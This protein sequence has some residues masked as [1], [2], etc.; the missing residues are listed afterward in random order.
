MLTE[1]TFLKTFSDETGQMIFAYDPSLKQF[2]YANPAFKNFLRRLGVTDT[3]PG[4]I[5]KMVHDEDKVFMKETFDQVVAGIIKLD[6][7]FRLNLPGQQ[8]IWLCLS[9]YLIQNGGT[10]VI[11]ANASDISEAKRN[12]EMLHKFASRKNAIMHII[13]H[14]LAGPLA[15]MK[16]L[17]SSLQTSLEA[18]SDPGLL[19]IV[20][21]IREISEQ[22]INL[23]NEFLQ[24][25]FLEAADTD[26]MLKRVNLAKRAEDI[27][28][29]YQDMDGTAGK[30]FRFHSPTN[31]IFAMLDDAKFML[32]INNLVW[33][34]IKFTPDD[35]E[36]KVSVLEEPD[37]VVLLVTDTGIGIPE[38]YHTALFDKFTPARRPGLKGE[39][40][41]GLGMS[42]I[43]TIVEWHHGSISFTSRENAG[44]T[45]KVT[46][47]KP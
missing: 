12:T 26:L 9:P 44:T 15:I 23:L 25:E 14:E 18:L 11:L 8:E 21:M 33:N 34:A 22:N 13:S 32:V 2:V 41:I 4:T 31:E 40:T 3:N 38:K 37:A 30:A 20:S 29:Q 43:K 19:R 5:F 35:G 24:A 17:S 46:L 1:F 42:V 45:F 28:R 47:P 10:Q 27:V 36:I 16:T 7:E 6:L 39:P